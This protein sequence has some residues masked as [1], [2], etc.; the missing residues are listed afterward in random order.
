LVEGPGE[1]ADAEN[2][3]GQF[4]LQIADPYLVSPK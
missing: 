1:F 3:R 2:R 4:R